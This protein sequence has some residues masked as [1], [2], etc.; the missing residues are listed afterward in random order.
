MCLEALVS[1]ARRALMEYYTSLL[2][3][4]FVLGVVAVVVVTEGVNY[5][6]KIG[7]ICSH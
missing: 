5:G 1:L 7:F 2:L 4:L 3:L 6:V